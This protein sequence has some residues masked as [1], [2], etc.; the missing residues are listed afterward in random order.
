M[1]RFLKKSLAATA[2]MACAF[3]QAATVSFE[4]PV[5]MPFV[6][7]GS[8]VTVGQFWIEAYSGANKPGAWVGSITDAGSC[9]GGLVCPSNNSSTFYASLDDAYFYFGRTDNKTFRVQSFLASFMGFADQTYPAVSGLLILAGFDAFGNLLATSSQIALSGPT[10]GQ[11][12]FS[13][14]GAAAMG[15]AFANTEF[16]YVRV[17][18]FACNAAGSC[19]RSSNQANFAIDDIV[20]V[21]EPA[22]WALVALGLTA[23]G[24]TARRRRSV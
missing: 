13:S 23:I 20:V 24:V 11:F 21:P 18:G 6:F 8:P 1:R 14:Y 9:A 5:D 2:L 7:E 3:A 12:N 4:E 19:N 17:L 15:A 22:S 10:G 16:S